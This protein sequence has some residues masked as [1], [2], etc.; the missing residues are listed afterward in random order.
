MTAY[1]DVYIK[2]DDL[3]G[4]GINVAARLEPLAEP[5]GICMY[6]HFMTRLKLKVISLK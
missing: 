1:G 2:E 5:G 3:F 4:E 6:R